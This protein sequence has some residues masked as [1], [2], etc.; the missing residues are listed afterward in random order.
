MTNKLKTFLPVITIG[1]IVVLGYVTVAKLNKDSTPP[2]PVVSPAINPNIEVFRKYTYTDSE[3]QQINLASLEGKVWV[4]DLMF[5]SCPAQCAMM[6]A[7][8]RSLQN[9]F[10]DVKNLR[11]VSLTVDP[12]TDTPEVLKRYAEKYK[13]D[14]KQWLFLTAPQDQTIELARSLFQIAADKDP[15]LHSNRFVLVDATG[16][17][18]GSFNSDET[19]FLDKMKAAITRQLALASAKNALG[20]DKKVN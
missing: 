7:K 3:G 18:Q 2:I 1:T 16:K 5:T 20:V 12:D 9:G 17:V 6:T 14:T 10:A 11:F 8:M 19:L 13:A 15:D 4:A